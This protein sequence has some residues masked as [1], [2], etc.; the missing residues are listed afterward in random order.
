MKID[1][2]RILPYLKRMNSPSYNMGNLDN[3]ENERLDFVA[4]DYVGE[5]VDSEADVLFVSGFPKDFDEHYSNLRDGGS[6]FFFTNGKDTVHK[7]ILQWRIAKKH[8]PEILV[9]KE[10]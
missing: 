1:F 5:L 7:K 2:R 4:K 3:H 6:V 10:E 9:M 8:S